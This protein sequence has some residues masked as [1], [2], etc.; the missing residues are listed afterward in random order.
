MDY[1][2]MA[3]PFLKEES[4]MCDYEV[5]SDEMA[6]MIGAAMHVVRHCPELGEMVEL[7]YHLNGSIRGRL[8][9][10]HSDVMH[11][12]DVYDKYQKLSGG[13]TKFVLPVGSA[14]ATALHVIRCKA[15]SVL[16]IA[17][18][19]NARERAVPENVLNI[20]NLLA[21]VLFAMCLH[22]NAEEGIEEVIFSS[23]SYGNQR[24]D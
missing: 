23:K 24:T 15:K 22:E 20:L 16:R 2:Y 9:V 3:Y 4:L 7:V 10:D 17:Y 19:I 11:W 18:A 14:G 1:R 13:M 6:S 8:A 12:N 5:A 21:N